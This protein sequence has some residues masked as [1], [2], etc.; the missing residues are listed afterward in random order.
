MRN[1][2]ITSQYW[3]DYY[4]NCNFQIAPLEDQTRK[5]IEKHVCRVEGDA[6]EIGCMPGRYLAVLGELG[7]LLNGVDWTSRVNT[8]L[9]RWLAAKKYKIGDFFNEDFT[10]F[11]TNNK[12]DLVCSFGFI[13]HFVDWK[14]ILIKHISFL[15]P[16]GLLM[17]STPNFR[18]LIHRL[19]HI[20][21]DY[22][23]YKRHNIDSMATN[24][25]RKI[26]LNNGLD[27]IFSGHF[28]EFD[29][30]VEPQERNRLQLKLIREVAKFKKIV[31]D[32]N[33]SMSG[34]SPY[35]GIIAKKK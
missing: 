32:N 15:K 28:G 35:C 34:L 30:W 7:Y 3:E 2:L 8:D 5:W 16:E 14:S 1:N 10:F 20:T 24:I 6:L 21:I 11:K 19:L 27:I 12:Y 25:W 22:E 33:I 18:G 4:S 29:F 17:V 23:N 26:A 9:P 31:T 13:E